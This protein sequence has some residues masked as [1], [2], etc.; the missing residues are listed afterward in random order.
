[1]ARLVIR[2]KSRWQKT[3]QVCKALMLFKGTSPENLLVF[4]EMHFNDV[5]FVHEIN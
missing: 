3:K 5:L 4:Y 2:L 1:M